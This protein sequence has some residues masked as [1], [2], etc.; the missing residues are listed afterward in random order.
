MDKLYN[1]LKKYSL[2]SVIELEKTDRQ[3]LA[4]QK[5]YISKKFDDGDYLFLTIAN[6]LVCYQLSGRGEDYWEEFVNSVR[7]L[8]INSFDDIEEFF[9]L[10]LPE[11]KNNKR[12]VNIKLK[13]I[14]KLCNFY[15]RDINWKHYYQNMDILAQ[16]LSSVMNQKITD[17]TIVFAVKMFGYAGR[18]VFGYVEYYPDVLVLPLDSRLKNIYK[19]YTKNK[20]YSKKDIQKFYLVLSQKLNIPPL[21][22]D[23]VLWLNYDKLI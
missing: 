23:T 2:E 19:K 3:F 22:L 16:D 15:N 21:H 5:L 20:E 7:D 6:A 8:K 9:V 1:K 13:R 14:K 4:L 11:S 10:F 12:L 17:K 18:N